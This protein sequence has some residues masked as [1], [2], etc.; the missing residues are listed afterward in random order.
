MKNNK[1]DVNIEETIEHFDKTHKQKKP[2]V[3]KRIIKY[4]MI[5]LLICLV[6][7]V[8]T[9]S[10][11]GESI[12]Q[13]SSKEGYV[14]IDC[15]GDDNLIYIYAY[16][17]SEPEG[18][19]EYQS[20]CDV[21]KTIKEQLI[22]EA[23][24]I[25]IRSDPD[26]TDDLV[27]YI[28][29][30][31]TIEDEKLAIKMDDF[32][33]KIC[34]TI[35]LKKF[36]DIEIAGDLEQQVKNYYECFDRETLTRN[37]DRG[38]STS[39]VEV[40]INGELRQEFVIKLPVEPIRISF[41]DLKFIDEKL[42]DKL[43]VKFSNPSSSTLKLSVLDTNLECGKKTFTMADEYKLLCNKTKGATSY[44]IQLKDSSGRIFFDEYQEPPEVKEE[45]NINIP[46][47]LFII[48]IVIVF[49][50]Y[51]NYQGKVKGKEKSAIDQLDEEI[52]NQ[53]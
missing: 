30:F 6:I 22:L 20:S 47:V 53:R 38:D 32:T 52:D 40:Y 24:K 12:V 16:D 36:S 18:R 39:I 3:F 8:A 27:N 13:E 5:F 2:P 23:Q 29:Y 10:A 42:D 33:D 19:L 49:V 48:V 34:F 45:S 4:L 9:K 31:D 25:M 37:T 41:S 17:S 14:K 26:E 44:Y 21:S 35:D 50:A 46:L 15:L 7:A 28:E 1:I 11:Y 51:N 43:D